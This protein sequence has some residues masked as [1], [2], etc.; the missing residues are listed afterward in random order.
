MNDPLSLNLYTYVSNNPL[1]YTDPTG[2]TS[3]AN[4][5]TGGDPFA[6]TN[7]STTKS[8]DRIIAARS[9]GTAAQKKLFLL[10]HNA[11]KLAG[12]PVRKLPDIM[13][14]F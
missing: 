13:T 12:L 14:V 7:L 5:A 3:D 2:H 4:G 1:I 8:V 10:N 11:A 9:L 6:F